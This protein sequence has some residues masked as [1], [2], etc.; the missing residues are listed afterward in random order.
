MQHS[1]QARHVSKLH[2]RHIDPVLIY[3]KG[4]AVSTASWRDRREEERCWTLLLL[5]LDLF[6]GYIFLLL[7]TISPYTGN[8]YLFH[9]N[10]GT[11]CISY[12]YTAL[13][14]LGRPIIVVARSK[15][16]TV[17]ARSNTGVVGSNPTQG[18]NICVRLFCVCVVL[19]VPRRRW[20]DNIK[21][22]LREIGWDG[23]DWMDMAHDRDQ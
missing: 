9:T 12:M 3:I 21:M 6:F 8:E 1:L 2:C 14:N 17:F 4:T 15:T 10:V 20:V 13:T 7:V 5:K 19:W 16:W 18:M 11:S 23:A 22:D